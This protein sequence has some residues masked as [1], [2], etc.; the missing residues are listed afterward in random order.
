MDQRSRGGP[1]APGTRRLSVGRAL[2]DTAAVKKLAVLVLL[3]ITALA[4]YLMW[5]RPAQ[6]SVPVAAEG[7]VPAG[8]ATAEIAR[9]RTE[10]RARGEVDVS[11]CSASGRILDQ[12]SGRGIAGALVQLRPRGFGSPTTPDDPGAPR[13]ATTDA[14]GAWT[15]SALTPGRYM[16]TASAADHVP[17]RRGDVALRASQDNPGLDL[18]LERGGHPLRGTVSDVGGGPIE[19]AVIAVESQGEGNMINFSRASYPAISDAD[20]S[21]VVQVRDGLY[22]VSAWHPDYT[23]DSETADVAG[24]PRSVALRLTPAAAIEASCARPRAAR[25]WRA[26]PSVTVRPSASAAAGRRPTRAAAFASITCGQG[27]T[28]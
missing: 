23:G 17:G 16:L 15:I 4:V 24:G 14:G 8:L 26:R 25:R 7:E 11:P 1:P 3:S 2:L 27:R 12:D 10:A 20:G 19:G 22:S 13:T 28:S 6:V 18:T 5:W 21:F 9:V